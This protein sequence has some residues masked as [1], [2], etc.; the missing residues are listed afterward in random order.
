M[1]FLIRWCRSVPC[2]AELQQGLTSHSPPRLQPALYQTR[3]WDVRHVEHWAKAWGFGMDSLPPVVVEVVKK[4]RW[5][6]TLHSCDCSHPW[7]NHESMGLKLCVQ[8]STPETCGGVLTPSHNH[9]VNRACAKSVR[10]AGMVCSSAWVALNPH[11]R[12][13]LVY[14][15][16]YSLERDFLGLY[17]R[18]AGFNWWF[19]PRKPWGRFLRCSCEMDRGSGD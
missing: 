2:G 7:V 10:Q 19:M 4:A 8:G 3:S 11:L 12:P 5:N 6:K 16:L 13:K 15:P 17:W 9:K 1:L 18:P 14:S